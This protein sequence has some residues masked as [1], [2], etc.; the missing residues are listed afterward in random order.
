MNAIPTIA[1][2]EPRRACSA[3][4]VGAQ[5]FHHLQVSAN[6]TRAPDPIEHDAPLRLYDALATAASVGRILHPAPAPV[7]VIP[8]ALAAC[9]PEEGHTRADLSSPHMPTTPA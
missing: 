6:H 9:S 1:K 5:S 7:M 4:S 2:E 3:T 8:T